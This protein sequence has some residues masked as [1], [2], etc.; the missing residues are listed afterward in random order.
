MGCSVATARVGGT[1]APQCGQ[2]WD[3]QRLNSRR[4]LLSSSDI[5]PK[6]ERTPGTAGRW[7]RARAAGT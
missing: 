1:W 5:V 6:V 7:C 3:P 4:R 2:A